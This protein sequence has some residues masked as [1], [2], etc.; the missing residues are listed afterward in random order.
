MKNLV[1]DAK[2]G[3]RFV[4]HCKQLLHSDVENV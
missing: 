3:D 1:K 2:A 4:F